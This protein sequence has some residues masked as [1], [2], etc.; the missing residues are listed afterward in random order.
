MHSAPSEQRITDQQT[1]PE[2]SRQQYQYGRRTIVFTLLG[3][4]WAGSQFAW[5]S[6]Q[7]LGLLGG[8]LVVLAWFVIYC[9]HQE[10]R[11]Y[12]SVIEPSL[13]KS[14]I[15]IFDVSLLAT[16]VAYIALVGSSYFIPLFIQCVIGISATGSGL[17][18]IPTMLTAIAGSLCAGILISST[19]RYKWIALAGTIFSIVGTVLLARLDTSSSYLEQNSS[20]TKE[21]LSY[22]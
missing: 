5:L 10:R 1:P 17:I 14:S 3:F 2:F 6:P 9:A 8:A 13:F 12:E 18:L 4:S 21:V 7:I 19:G 22:E 16:T 15:R 20:Q 11:G